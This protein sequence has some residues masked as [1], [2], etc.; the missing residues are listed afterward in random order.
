MKPLD[1]EGRRFGMLV[2]VEELPRLNGMR[3]WRL[4]CD[5]GGERIAMQKAFASGGRMR[6][7]GCANRHAVVHN[8]SNSP[9]YRHWINM[10]SR[11]ENPNTPGYEHYG[12]RG[13]SVCK[14]WRHSFEAFFQD[15]GERPSPQHSV[16]RIDVNG[17]YEPDNCRW[18]DPHTQGRNTRCNHIVVFQGREMTLAEAAD[19]S[20]VTYNTVLYRLKRGW[21][22]EAAILR[23][24]QR[25]RRP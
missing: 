9:E 17:N 4:K 19:H 11:C 20:P 16:D 25:G 6:S 3:Q 2:A 14:R 15:M 23:P 18:A 8:L 5:C 13:I 24:Q 21:P 22:P 10:I 1:I 12:G 7:C